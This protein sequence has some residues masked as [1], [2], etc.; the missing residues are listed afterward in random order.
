MFNFTADRGATGHV[1]ICASLCSYSHWDLLLGL[2]RRELESPACDLCNAH[3]RCREWP[4]GH[5]R[6]HPAAACRPA[7]GAKVMATAGQSEIHEA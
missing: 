1:D 2:Q 7:Q 3:V 5:I 6:A 4:Q